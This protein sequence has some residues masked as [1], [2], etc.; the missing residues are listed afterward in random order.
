MLFMKVLGIDFD[1][2]IHDSLEMCAKAST[3]AHNELGVD[4]IITPKLIRE[5]STK[6]GNGIPLPQHLTQ[7]VVWA[8]YL[9][10]LQND[11]QLAPMVKYTDI[12]LEEAIKRYD[13]VVVISGS[14]KNIIESF[15]DKNSLPKIKIISVIGSKEKYLASEKVTTY[16]GDMVQDGL[17]AISANAKFIGVLH[18][19]AFTDSSALIEFKKRNP[20]NNIILVQTLLDCIEHFE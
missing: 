20:S 19:A 15:L 2:L 7:E 18:D 16:I 9:E 14:P 3:H 6:R 1:G 13:K 5:N 17:D 10:I 4:I 11:L 8:K 12:F